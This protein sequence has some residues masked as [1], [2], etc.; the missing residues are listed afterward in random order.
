MCPGYEYLGAVIAD[1]GARAL[2]HPLTGTYIYGTPS[3]PSLPFRL[4]LRHCQGLS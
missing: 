3:S 4:Q 2:T 1:A